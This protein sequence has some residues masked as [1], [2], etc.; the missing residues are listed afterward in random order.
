MIPGKIHSFLRFMWYE[1]NN[2]VVRT[3]ILDFS[4]S[5][6]DEIDIIPWI[7]RLIICCLA[8]N[9]NLPRARVGGSKSSVSFYGLFGLILAELEQ[10]HDHRQRSQQIYS[11]KQRWRASKKNL[12]KYFFFVKQR[13]PFKFFGVFIVKKRS[14]LKMHM[15]QPNA[16]FCTNIY[17][18]FSIQTFCVEEEED[19]L[20]VE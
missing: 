18:I 19:R 5:I 4:R 13:T 20:W 6:Y 12:K 16:V 10:L 9:R 7:L 14:P 11:S 8:N 1:K 15:C 2:L 3:W 17:F